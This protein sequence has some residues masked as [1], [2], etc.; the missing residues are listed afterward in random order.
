MWQ[1][2]LLRSLES[3]IYADYKHPAPN[4]AN[5][6]NSFPYLW[7][8]PFTQAGLKSG[9]QFRHIASLLLS[10]ATVWKSFAAQNVAK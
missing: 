3:L 1:M 8:G 9:L 2:S 7:H 10:K 5:F 6:S 4:G